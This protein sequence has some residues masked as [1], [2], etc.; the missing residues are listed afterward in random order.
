M[1]RNND[2]LEGYENMPFVRYDDSALDK[3]CVRVGYDE[4]PNREISGV[5]KANYYEDGKLT[6]LYSSQENHVGVI[7]ATRLGKT[8]SYVIPTVLS[9]ARQK[10]KKSLIISDCKGEIYRYTAATLRAAGYNVKLINFR[11]YEHSECWNP[12]TYIYRKYRSAVKIADTINVG[13]DGSEVF[14]EFRGVRYTDQNE[15]DKIIERVKKIMIEDV[16]NDIDQLAVTIVPTVNTREPYWED[17]AREVL[18]AILVAMLEDSDKVTNP[19]TEDTFSF[20]TIVEI[21]TRFSANDNKSFYDGGYFTRRSSDSQSYKMIKNVLINNAGT[22][23]SCILSTFNTSIAV[24][25]EVAARVITRAN[26]FEMSDLVDSPTVV[27]INYRDEQKVHYRLIG[28]F[29]QEAYRYL[30]AYANDKPR[31]RLDT[32]LYFILD[33]FGNFPQLVGF[34]TVISASGGR[35]IFFILILQSYAQLENVY[36][37]AVAAI[38]RDNLNMHV[39]FGSNNPETLDAFSKE[40]GQITRISPLSALNGSG[41]SIENY[42][43]ETIANVPKSMLAHLEPGECVITEANAGYVMF[44]RL[45]RYYMCDEY[46]DLPQESCAEY[47]CPINPFDDRYIFSFTASSTGGGRRGL[48]DDFDF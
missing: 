40:C 35:N 9:F 14:Y 31:G 8:T 6:Q 37:K 4:L 48:F 5:L 18:K 25:K 34:D 45:E 22:T 23:A 17:S 33:E 43:M 19:I 24:F 7:A 42:Q 30:I 1:Q 38:I 2:I 11:E 15:L 10:V 36:G 20:N 21:T 47:K 39:F 3:T 26:S 29:V 16:Y 28:M 13:F 41:Q 44:S 27:F 12:L 32:P 46:N